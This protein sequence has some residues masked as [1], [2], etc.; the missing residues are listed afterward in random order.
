MN[1]ANL[2]K[3]P[4]L[5]FNRQNYHLDKP[6]VLDRMPESIAC[7]HCPKMFILR[8]FKKTSDLPNPQRPYAIYDSCSERESKSW[9]EQQQQLN[10]SNSWGLWAH[11]SLCPLVAVQ[12]SRLVLMV[13]IHHCIHTKTRHFSSHVA[14]CIQS[15]EHAHSL[16]DI[17]SPKF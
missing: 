3:L 8:H 12:I 5:I 16:L 6:R 15:N 13:A 10:Q 7:G 17:H 11:F 2:E 9:S 14:I 1:L 4:N